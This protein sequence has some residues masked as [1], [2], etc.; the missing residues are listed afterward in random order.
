MKVLRSFYFFIHKRECYQITVTKTLTFVFDC[1]MSERLHS[2]CSLAVSLLQSS[3]ALIDREGFLF[4]QR[5][6]SCLRSLRTLCEHKQVN[7]QTDT[8]IAS[9]SPNTLLPGGSEK[10]SLKI[11]N[12]RTSKQITVNRCVVFHVSGLQ[13]Y[14][15]S[16]GERKQSLLYVICLFL[17][18]L[19]SENYE[20]TTKSSVLVCMCVSEYAWVVL[21]ERNSVQP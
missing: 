8:Q 14:S 20:N 9:P 4:F 5:C 3:N 19:F 16:R 11:T 10:Q 21:R 6:W 17:Y 13:W 15:C 18:C 2:S 1:N 12:R 7:K